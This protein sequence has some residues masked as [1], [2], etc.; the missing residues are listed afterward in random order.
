[1]RTAVALGL[2]SCACATGG[3]RVPSSLAPGVR[4]AHDLVEPRSEG[5]VRLRAVEKPAFL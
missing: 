5:S 1:M 4:P 3:P 2:L